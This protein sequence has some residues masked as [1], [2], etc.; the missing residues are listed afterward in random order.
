MKLSPLRLNLSSKI[1]KQLYVGLK[2]AQC[3]I[4]LLPDILCT[5]V[6]TF[7]STQ[8]NYRGYLTFLSSAWHLPDI[9]RVRFQPTYSNR[10]TLDPRFAHILR[11]W[12]KV[13]LVL[14][15]RQLSLSWFSLNQVVLEAEN[16]AS[17]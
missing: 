7:V 15:I 6:I 3:H 4:L 12:N 13:F 17:L 14:R 9:F 10:L 2:F 8:N 16:K 11:S 1:G 5:L